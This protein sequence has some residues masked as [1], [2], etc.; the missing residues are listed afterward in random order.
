MAGGRGRDATRRRWALELVGLNLGV[1]AG[2]GLITVGLVILLIGLIWSAGRR[3]RNLSD[4]PPA[5]RAMIAGGLLLA[6]VGVL[7]GAL[8]T[9]VNGA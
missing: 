1:L 6:A 2:Y 5:I 3:L 7:V 9:I 4:D 8:A